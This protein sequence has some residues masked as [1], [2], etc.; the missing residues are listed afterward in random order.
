MKS[1]LLVATLAFLAGCATY[2]AKIA[3]LRPQL[4]SGQY[5]A[6]LATIDDQT[7]EKD[8]LLYY[9]ER[10]TIL[11]YADRWQES[12]ESFAAAER[13]FAELPGF[14]RYCAALPTGLI[15]LAQRARAVERFPLESAPAPG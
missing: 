4:A 13:T 2:S 15:E 12:N 5:D 1:F 7:G 6:A 8:L 11:H 9:L 3:N 10:G 14:L